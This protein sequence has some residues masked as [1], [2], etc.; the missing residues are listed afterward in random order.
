MSKSSSVIG[1]HRD[2]IFF[3]FNGAVREVEFRYH[4]CGYLY[5]FIKKQLQGHEHIVIV[6]HT[7]TFS[8]PPLFPPRGYWKKS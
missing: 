6:G 4:C 5:S 1:R 8:L 2:F 3:V 7:L